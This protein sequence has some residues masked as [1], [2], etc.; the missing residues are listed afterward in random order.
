MPAKVLLLMFVMLL[1]P[2]VSDALRCG[3]T[4]VGRGDHALEVL[5]KCGEPDYATSWEL[6]RRYSDD[7]YRYSRRQVVVEEWTYNFGR[8]RFMKVLRFENGYLV[9][10][11]SAG[12]GF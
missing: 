3:R 10:I 6:N 8:Q 12:Y 4:L 5:S 2:A 7:N 9:S 1:F 11:A